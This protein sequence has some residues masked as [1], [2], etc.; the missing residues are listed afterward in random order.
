MSN[1]AFF[2][3]FLVQLIFFL[4]AASLKGTE[5]PSRKLTGHLGH[6][7]TENKSQFGPVRTAGDREL[8]GKSI[9]V[10]RG[11][12]GGGCST[13][14]HTH[15]CLSF[16]DRK[17]RVTPPRCRSCIWLYSRAK[18]NINSNCSRDKSLHLTDTLPLASLLSSR[19]E[20]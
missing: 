12:P 11:S 10:G 2:F 20:Y 14:T 9:P 18:S 15:P 8:D 3:F 19:S 1:L 7:L 13:H 17:G 6:H 16:P 4:A 5:T